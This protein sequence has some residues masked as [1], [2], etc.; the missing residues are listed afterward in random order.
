MAVLYRECRAGPGEDAADGS[1]RVTCTVRVKPGETTGMVTLEDG[2]PLDMAEFIFHVFPDRGYREIRSDVPGWRVVALGSGDGGGSV[3]VSGSQLLFRAGDPWRALAGSVAVSRLIR[4]QRRLIFFHA[5]SIGVSGSG[6]MLIGPK[7]A[8]KTTLSLALAARG[9]SF[10]GDE[11]AGVRLGSFELVPLRRSLA[12]RSGP[13]ADAV[14]DAL[15]R[16]TAPLEIYPDGSE[17][18]RAQAAELFPSPPPT[19]LP[20]GAVVFLCGFGP[21][22]RLERFEPG[23]EHLQE[24]TPIGAT[25]WAMSPARRA[26]DMLSL[27]SRARCY[28][29]VMGGPEDSAACIERVMEE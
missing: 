4:L 3:A 22:A 12:I 26:F 2:E 5:A 8:G 10:L 14:S 29:M 9:H 11:I 6:V 16:M 24:L 17:R 21:E 25:L 15:E 28:R 7:G 13:R 23:R 20:L 18:L 27:L 19:S 1:S